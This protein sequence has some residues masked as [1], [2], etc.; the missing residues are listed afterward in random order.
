MAVNEN[1]FVDENIAL[2]CPAC[3]GEY[4]LTFQICPA[5]GLPLTK[6]KIGVVALTPSSASI[7]ATEEADQELFES[8]STDMA[9]TPTEPI[10][11]A[12][13]ESITQGLYSAAPAIDHGQDSFEENP[14]P[15]RQHRRQRELFGYELDNPE[16]P[17]SK[18]TKNAERPG[19]RVAAIALVIT[20]TLFT[21]AALYTLLSAGAR[22]PSLPSTDPVNESAMTQ[23]APFIPTPE[24][25]RDY[26]EEP[27]PADQPES[28][29]APSGKQAREAQPQKPA[30]RSTQAGG[31]DAP[32]STRQTPSPGSQPSVQS[33]QKRPVIDVSAPVPSQATDGR[34]YARLVRSRA[35]KTPAGYRYDLTF[36]LQERAGRSMRWDR[37]TISSISATG[38]KRNQTIPFPHYLSA[39]GMLTFTVSV[40][41]Q[42]GSEADWRGR[43]VC[44]GS[45]ADNTGAPLRASFGATVAPW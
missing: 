3:A 16:E 42:G 27:P 11:F 37:L 30:P 10:Q 29:T 44:T 2:Y 25:A 34:V 24:E 41:M 17:E 35:R 22:R 21:L 31:A 43:I 20:L 18:D 28:K 36:N 12:Q 38:T 32:S 6:R 23:A 4:P 45:G 9:I 5:H 33:P 39:S 7:Q 19:F 26:V 8:D 13:D 15:I 14:N 1:N 40:E